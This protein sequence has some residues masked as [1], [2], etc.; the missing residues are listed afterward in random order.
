MDSL[1]Y[2]L[3]NGMTL[4]EIERLKERDGLTIDQ[5]AEAAES[6]IARNGS[7]TGD[8]L[9][10]E[11][12][13][14]FDT[15]DTPNFPVESL[16]GPL[17]AF[18]EC[19]AESTQTPE[20]MAGI[21]SLGVLATAFQSKYEVEVTPDWREPLCLYPVAVAPPGERKSAVISALTKPIYEYEAERRQ[22]EAVEIDQNRTERKLLEKA[23]QAAQDRATKGK[24]A[25]LEA[26]R[27]EALALSA[28]LAQFQEKHPFRLL[29]DDTTPEKLVDIM[30]TQNGCI[31]VASAEGGIFDSMAGRYDKGANFD[32]YLKG[33]AGDPITVDRVGRRQNRIDA[34]RLTMILTIQ[35]EVL[36]G[37]MSNATMR[38]RGLCGRFLYVMCKSKVGQRAVSPPPVPEAVKANYRS[39]VR[40]I[41]A[42]PGAGTIRLSPE[43][44]GIRKQYQEHSEAKLGNEWEFMRDWGC[45]LVG[46][47]VRIAA[48]MHAAQVQGDPAESLISPEVMAS[49]V[50]IAEFLGV[51]AMAA[52]QIMGADEDFEDAK[53][54]WRRIQSTD[55][56][57]ISKRDLFTTCQ[58]KFKKV[59]NIEPAI[60]TLSDMGYLREIERQTG[61]RPSKIIIVNPLAKGAKH[62]KAS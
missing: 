51:H 47:M 16:P 7:L 46:A 36:S 30:D 5:L 1:N 24:R 44:D 34:P 2:L 49:A 43:A 42:D 19:L 50:S 10:W 3:E 11:E 58:S 54:L 39:F 35:P 56:E 62:A 40:R 37:L 14:P 12:P 13:I 15:I 31:T 52:Y 26:G 18:V 61:G 55:Q 25:D 17:S 28:E 53:Y 45:K 38:G 60:R 59:E 4:E 22:A 27:E 48:L 8:F 32:V 41:L 6:I 9:A 23:L 20:E 29:A 57:E 33:H 21:L